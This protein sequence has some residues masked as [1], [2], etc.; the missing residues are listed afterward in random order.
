MIYSKLIIY[1]WLALYLLY[2]YESLSNYNKT[3]YQ[4]VLLLLREL[5]PNLASIHIRGKEGRILS[6][7]SKGKSRRH[8]PASE[9]YDK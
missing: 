9:I 8:I 4:P 3:K 2:S 1:H 6:L 7:H 5:G